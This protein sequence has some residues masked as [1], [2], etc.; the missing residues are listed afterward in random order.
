MSWGSS[1]LTAPALLKGKVSVPGRQPLVSSSAHH[2][3][4]C[5]LDIRLDLHLGLLGMELLDLEWS[6]LCVSVLH[7]CVC[8]WKYLSKCS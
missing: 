8:E 1:V 7:V 2:P 6:T 3:A 4:L 5:L